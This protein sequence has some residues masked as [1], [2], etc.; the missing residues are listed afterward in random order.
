MGQI[1]NLWPV[2]YLV[3]SNCFQVGLC[4]KLLLLGIILARWRRRLCV[5]R[6]YDMFSCATYLLLCKAIC[7]LN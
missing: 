7:T 5:G 4:I 3:M 1:C 6:I 2:I